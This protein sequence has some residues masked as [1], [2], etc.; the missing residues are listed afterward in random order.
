VLYEKNIAYGNGAGAGINCDGEAD[1]IYRNNLIYGNS[2][3]GMT[4]YAINAG[5]PS[6]N[7]KIYNNTVLEPAS[8]RYC[9]LIGNGCINNKF[10]NNILYNAGPAKGSF[11]IWTP[12]PTGFESDYNVVTTGGFNTN[13]EATIGGTS[14]A[15]WQALGYDTH[16]L[17][18]V[19]ADLFVNPGADDYRLKAGSPAIDAGITLAEVTD[20]I[21][22][23]PRPVGAAYDI[24]AY[25]YGGTPTVQTPTISPP[26]GTY[27]GSV[28]VSIDCT[29]PGAEIRYT[30]DG[31]DPTPS[32]T[33]YSGPFGLSTSATVKARGY[34]S[35]Y[36]P[37]A[38]AIAAY[39]IESGTVT[40]VT[41]QQGLNSYTGWADNWFS[42]DFPTQ[43]FGAD[44]STHLQYH[45]ADG[46]LHG[47]DI[48]SLPATATVQSAVFHLYV[49]DLGTSGSPSIAAHRMLTHW[50]EME[51][52]YE[53]AT[54]SVTWGLPGLQS[55]ADYDGTAAGTSAVLTSLGYTTIDITSLVSAW[56][57]G[58]YTNEGLLLK[59]ASPHHIKTYMKEASQS[60]RPKL[61]VTLFEASAEKVETPTFSPPGGTYPGAVDVTI[62]CSTSGAEIRYTTDGT[63]P[64]ESSTLYTGPVHVAATTTLKARG[65]ASGYDPSDVASAT[66]TISGTVA[67]PAFA[68]PAGFF[69]GPVDVTMTSA[70]PSAQIRY[71]TNGAAP[72]ATS[73]LY[74]GPVH[75]ASTTNLKAAAFWGPL[76]SSVTSGVYYIDTQGPLTSSV[77]TLPTVVRQTTDLSITLTAIADDSA[78]GASDIAG[79]EYFL[80]TDPGVGNGT[81]MSAADGSFNS[82]S[83]A[84]I[85]TVN[86][87]SWTQGSYRIYV[88]ARDE[89]GHWGATSSVLVPVVSNPSGRATGRVWG[90]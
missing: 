62:S 80:G 20:D 54:A 1:S 83:E 18:S 57:E 44:G 32:S 43:N 90:T 25:E 40:E 48:S 84:L 82:E 70:T 10:F 42:E 12:S 30:T 39:T 77:A 73:T 81:A 64:T 9:V 23:V 27:A 67:A 13:G 38:I 26:A 7:N 45:T 69:P 47:F 19:P 53:R 68:P 11:T 15:E 75:I 33:L 79:A 14:L 66:Y 24:G 29:T 37:S 85:A 52:T 59:L 6:S 61:V 28:A 56:H 31:A 46:Q 72:T 16:S 4:F 41:L 51:S 63:D 2:G 50:E 3:N 88:R 34:A 87:S 76:Q 8:T 58:T 65:Y 60:Y 36:D 35:G 89:G 21:L 17:T 78:T 71:T 22:G 55:G 74:T 49:H 86:T 5:Q